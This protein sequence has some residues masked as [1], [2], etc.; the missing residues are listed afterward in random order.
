VIAIDTNVLVRYVVG[1][2]P[3]QTARATTLIEQ[4][5][6]ESRPAFIAT[7]VLAELVWVLE[8]CYP[9]SKEQIV[10]VLEQ[11]LRTRQFVVEQAELVWQAVRSFVASKADFA[12]CLIERIAAARDCEAAVTF[13]KAAATAGMKLLS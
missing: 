3:A 6:D 7:I 12:D 4:E 9:S 1:D 11:V 8:S 2:D 5:C 13:D 10:T